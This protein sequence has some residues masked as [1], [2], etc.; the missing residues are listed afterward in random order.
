MAS[1][2]EDFA[3]VKEIAKNALKTAKKTLSNAWSSVVKTSTVVKDKVVTFFK[4]DD[5]GSTLRAGWSK[6]NALSEKPWFKPALIGTGAALVLALCIT[7]GILLSRID[8]TLDKID[9]I[10]DSELSLADLD[11]D[12]VELDNSGEGEVSGADSFT[13]D[14]MGMLDEDLN[15]AQEQEGLRSKEG[16]T[17][18]LLLGIDARK[19][20]STKSRS[21]VIMILSINDN[22]KSITMTSIMRDTYVN[23]PG[24]KKNDKINAACAYG[25][26]KLTVKTVEETFGIKIDHFVLVNFYAFID[27][28]D[29]LGGVT[30]DISPEEMKTANLYIEEINQKTG[31]K[32]DDGKL[33]KTGV[34]K[35]TGKQA[36]GYVRNRYDFDDTSGENHD[37]ARTARQRE[38]LG[39]LI[40]KAKDASYSTL[41]DIVDDVA[42]NMSTDMSNSEILDF[43]ADA[44][45]YKD[46]VVSQSRLPLDGTFKG[47]N[48]NGMWVIRMLDVDANK[49]ALYKS[50]FGE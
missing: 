38:V 36:I 42:G 5:N 35:L 39:Q 8:K 45:S 14:E 10:S 17:N 9:R 34:L 25:G 47:G 16:V 24:R 3:A 48:Y 31:K 15:K 30:V 40:E 11:L 29:A 12:S 27:A 4:G 26:P 13:A 37:Y 1:F 20:K 50:A 33:K 41:I 7:G 32:L 21:D 44:A 23:I 18:I 22:N 2:S 46:Y 43:A 49:Q 6:V 28:V 19:V